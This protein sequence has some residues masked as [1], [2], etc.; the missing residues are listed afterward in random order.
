[1]FNKSAQSN[2]GKGLHCCESLRWG[3]LQPAYVAEAQSRPV[4]SVPLRRGVHSG[5]C[6]LRRKVTVCGDRQ[7]HFA[8]CICFIVEKSLIFC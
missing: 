1:M 3:R 4:R 8:A 5:I 6:M 2:L 7:Q